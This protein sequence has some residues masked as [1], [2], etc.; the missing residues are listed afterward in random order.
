ME[1]F[2]QNVEVH[3]SSAHTSDDVKPDVT[4]DQNQKTQPKE[5]RAEDWVRRLVRLWLC[6]LASLPIKV[7]NI[8]EVNWLCRRN[9]RVTSFKKLCEYTER[10]GFIESLEYD[11]K[12]F[13]KRD[14]RLLA[15]KNHV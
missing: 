5:R 14:L 11:M 6:S 2:L 3:P 10:G 8:D 1:H 4:P 13:S 15:A 12:K 9:Y 7:R